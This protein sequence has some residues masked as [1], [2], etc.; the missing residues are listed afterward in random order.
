[1]KIDINWHQVNAKLPLLQVR[2]QNILYITI[3]LHHFLMG[4]RYKYR[5]L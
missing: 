5:L 3:P 2:I 1:M 4:G